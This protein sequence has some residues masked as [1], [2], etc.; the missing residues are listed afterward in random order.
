[1]TDTPAG[2]D[3]GAADRPPSDDEAALVQAARTRNRRRRTLVL[4]AQIGLIVAVLGGW[5]LGASSGALDKFTYGSPHGVVRP[6]R[7]PG[8]SHGTSLGSIWHNI[9]VTMRGDR[10][11]LPHRHRRRRGAAASR[12]A[13]YGCWPT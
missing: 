12:W 2:A 6:A 10:L 8:S 1:M 3:P 4:L 7:V 11:R 13:G 9:A 5:Q